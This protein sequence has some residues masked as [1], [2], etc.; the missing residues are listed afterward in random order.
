M[1][2]RSWLAR[3]VLHS[4]G[5]KAPSR[6]GRRRMELATS[7]DDCVAF[8]A[9]T[10]AEY[11]IL[12][13]Q[14]VLPWEW[15][16]LL[17]HGDLAALRY[18]SEGCWEQ[19]ALP[20]DEGPVATWQAARALL[21]ADLLDLAE[22]CGLSLSDLQQSVVIPLEL[23]LAECSEAYDWGPEEW[24]VAVDAVFSARRRR[25]LHPFTRQPPTSD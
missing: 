11:R 19:P 17:A 3:H 1:S 15:T 6:P 14:T 16:N 21:S 9:G 25:T 2:L 8:L 4:P 20:V 22:V 7:V 12:H 23:E 18:V 5:P 10:L 24:L 13:G